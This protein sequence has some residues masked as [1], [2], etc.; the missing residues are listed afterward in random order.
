M[1]PSGYTCLICGGSQ[2]DKPSTC[3]QYRVEMELLCSKFKLEE[4][5][6]LPLLKKTALSS[7]LRRHSHD[8][9]LNDE[10][11]NEND[12][13][14]EGD[15]AEGDEEESK[16]ESKS[17]VSV[18]SGASITGTANK[19]E[20]KVNPDDMVKEIAKFRKRNERATENECDGIFCTGTQECYETTFV[21]GFPATNKKGLDSKRSPRLNYAIGTYKWETNFTIDD[22]PCR[23][24][25]WHFLKVSD[26][27][28][29]NEIYCHYCFIHDTVKK[30]IK[31][32][33]DGIAAMG[34][35]DSDN[36]ELCDSDDDNDK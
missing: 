16:S 9:D 1:A 19:E 26:R 12:E 33:D 36:D 6:V 5:D 32:M 35:G 34:F 22:V 31:I 21:G 15:D 13:D 11:D 25:A 7:L 4:K 20:I 10:N 8:D 27:Q 17:E 14:A 23:P 30:K 24:E 2:W 28:I 3:A 18:P 29:M